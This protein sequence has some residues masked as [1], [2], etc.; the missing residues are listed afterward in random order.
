MLVEQ[1]NQFG[2]IRQRAGQAV[3]LVDDNH[4][5]LAGPHVV[6]QPL[7]GWPISVAA[8]VAAVVI[9]SAQQG[10]GGMRLAADIGLRGIILGVEGIKVLLQPLVSR[11]AGIDR[12]A[13]GR[14]GR[15]AEDR[16]DGLS[17]RPKNRGPFQRV[18]V[19]ANA[20]LERLG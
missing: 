2:K 8:G 20:T 1:F 11:D 4:I 12:A 15:H 14:S 13:N 16:C 6:Q 18:P 7:Q 19:I 9:F 10:P 3:D 17:R 5:D